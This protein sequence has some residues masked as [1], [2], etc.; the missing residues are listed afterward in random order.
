MSQLSREEIG[1][2]RREFLGQRTSINSEAGREAR[3]TTTA[4]NTDSHLIYR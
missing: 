2:L 1:S 3:V 4:P